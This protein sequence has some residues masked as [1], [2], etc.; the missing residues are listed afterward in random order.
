MRTSV[1]PI[2]AGMSG[3]RQEPLLTG[4]QLRPG[5]LLTGPTWHSVRLVVEVRGQ[6]ITTTRLG[7]PVPFPDHVHS[8]TMYGARE[9]VCGYRRS[10]ASTF[11]PTE[12]GL[13]RTY[14]LIP[15]GELEVV[16]AHTVYA[17]GRGSLVVATG[18]QWAQQIPIVPLL[19]PVWT[20]PQALRGQL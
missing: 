7:A 8:S 20:M 15:R 4:D 11:L 3:T 10:Q 14:M 18:G 5:V 1:D 9:C 13:A 12:P 2:V 17:D 19:W 16:D 6:M